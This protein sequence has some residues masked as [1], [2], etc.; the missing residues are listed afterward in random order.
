MIRFGTNMDAHGHEHREE[1]HA[2]A[3]P[4]GTLAFVFKE[5]RKLAE[6]SPTPSAER[7]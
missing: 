2:V 7:K 4:N 5:S 3:T 6:H 1:K